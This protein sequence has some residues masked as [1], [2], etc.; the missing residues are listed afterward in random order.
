M[1]VVD[2]ASERIHVPEIRFPF[3]TLFYSYPVPG[4]SRARN[5]VL[6]SVNGD[7]LALMDDDATADP[8]WLSAALPH[9]QEPEVCCVTGTIRPLESKTE[10]QR[11]Q[12]PVQGDVVR[13][14]ERGQFDPVTTSPGKGANLLV[15]TSWIRQYRFPELFGPGTPTFAA[16]EHY[17]FHK[18]VHSG[19]RICFEPKAVVYH[20]FVE[21]EKDFRIRAKR[22]AV[23]RGAYLVKFAFTEAGYRLHT[24][25][26]LLQRCMGRPGAASDIPTATRNTGFLLGGFALVR[27]FFQEGHSSGVTCRLIAEFPE[28]S[29]R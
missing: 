13:Y 12:T 27:S 4:L 15:R 26:Y 28:K 14:Y 24:W 16:D 21:T 25:R 9:F 29:G 5:S 18:V 2:N 17:L 22:R 1:I 6:D 20:D 10:W 23:S 7:I 8:D 3:H 11:I 19:K